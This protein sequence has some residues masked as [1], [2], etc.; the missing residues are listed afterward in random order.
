MKRGK[1][2]KHEYSIRDGSIISIK[3]LPL[4][5]CRIVQI[6]LCA[7]R[8]ALKKKNLKI[9]IFINVL[10]C[11]EMSTKLVSESMVYDFALRII[12]AF[13]VNRLRDKP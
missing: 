5:I 12:F 13:C 7:Y 1:N 11:M 3:G 9:V 2:L 4:K 8:Q 10:G 6:I